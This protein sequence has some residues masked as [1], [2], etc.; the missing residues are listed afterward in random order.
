MR[1]NDFDKLWRK[2]TYICILKSGG[3]SFSTSLI[4][5]SSAN[6]K[7]W[8]V[9]LST[10][11]NNNARLTAALQESTSNVEEWKRQ[12]QAYKEDNQ[13]MKQKV[14]E[15]E[16]ARGNADAAADLRKEINAMREK[17]DGQ[18][19]QLKAKEDE[20]RALKEKV[21]SGDLKVNYSRIAL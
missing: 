3:V 5:D 14:L 21:G 19:L 15:A 13:R 2:G 18:V 17:V 4:F 16:A 9:E 1:M 10:L 12:L 6:A 8:E 20:L 7:K 11:K